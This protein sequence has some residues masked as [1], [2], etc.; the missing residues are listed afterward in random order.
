MTFSSIAHQ[1]IP[2]N[3]TK[4]AGFVIIIA[5]GN[6]VNT[7]ASGD[8]TKGVPAN[9]IRVEEENRPSRIKADDTD[10]IAIR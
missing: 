2:Y 6:E 3:G 4:F 8:W 1:P 10:S 9:R 7:H 5:N